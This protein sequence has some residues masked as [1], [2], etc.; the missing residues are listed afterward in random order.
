MHHWNDQ[1]IGL[2]RDVIEES[3]E[4]YETERMGHIS[5]PFESD[6]YDGVQYVMSTTFDKNK[7]PETGGFKPASEH[8]GFVYL[9]TG[10]KM[11]YKHTARNPPDSE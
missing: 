3:W 4:D 7:Y 5:V 10:E 8:D 9:P 1:Q 6:E 11:R 2:W